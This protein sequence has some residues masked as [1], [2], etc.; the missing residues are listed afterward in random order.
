[1]LGRA[2]PR[3]VF[4]DEAPLK[5]PVEGVSTFAKTFPERGPRD[6]KGRSLRDFDLETRL[7]RYRLSYMIYSPAFDALPQAV[8]ERIYRR[9]RESCAPEVIEILRDTKPG[10]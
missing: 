8:R 4:E 10:F 2:V 5:E 6:R 9:I 1:M 3:A 7:F